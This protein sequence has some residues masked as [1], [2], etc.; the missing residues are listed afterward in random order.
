MTA[1]FTLLVRV[2]YYHA[3]LIRY[4]R[5]PFSRHTGAHEYRNWVDVPLVLL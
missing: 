1:A 5:P 2:S 3:V 4:A